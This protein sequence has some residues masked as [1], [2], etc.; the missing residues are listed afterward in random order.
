MYSLSLD[1]MG[2]E[3]TDY[4]KW[5]MA[6][7]DIIKRYRIWLSKCLAF[8]VKNIKIF[9]LEVLQSIFHSSEY[10]ITFKF[11]YLFL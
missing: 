9:D 7:R 11:N 3:I 8:T 1:A 5:L 4:N 6:I 2:L 10:I